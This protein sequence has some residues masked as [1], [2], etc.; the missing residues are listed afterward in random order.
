[1]N[2]SVSSAAD[3]GELEV[4]VELGDGEEK[5]HGVILVDLHQCQRIEMA[6]G[7]AGLDSYVMQLALTFCADHGVDAAV[8]PTF[9]EYLKSQIQDNHGSP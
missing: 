8:A 7:A 2:D 5:Q 6:D 9:V 3:L 4:V 1:M